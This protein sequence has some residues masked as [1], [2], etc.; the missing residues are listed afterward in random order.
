MVP[1]RPDEAIKRVINVAEQNG[2][3][4]RYAAIP[5]DD[6]LMRQ[7]DAG[8]LDISELDQPT[9]IAIKDLAYQLAS[10]WCR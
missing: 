9:R 7:L 3:S 8:L 1:R 2:K 10:G 6:A 4:R 5:R